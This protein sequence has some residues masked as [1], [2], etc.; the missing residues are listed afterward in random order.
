MHDMFVGRCWLG[1]FDEASTQYGGMLEAEVFSGK[2]NDSFF[3]K[4]LVREHQLKQREEC[5]LHGVLT[6]FV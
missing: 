6:A 5:S 1:A 2:D 3:G 4:V